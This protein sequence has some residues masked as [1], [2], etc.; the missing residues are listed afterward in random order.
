MLV[1]L[2]YASRA[3]DGID[4]A[5][6]K[7]IQEQSRA[8]N[9]EHGI[10]GILCAHP[11]GGVFIQVLEGGRE[12]VNRLFGNIVRDQRHADVTILDYAEI[13]E[14]R[15]AGWR[16]GNVDLNKVNLSSILR[17]S[18]KSELDPF[19]MSGPSALALL[20][21]LASSAAIGSYDGP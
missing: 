20:E 12:P 21:E 2:L 3:V 15:F 7:S 19:S 14:R 1:R 11:Q 16:M 4:Q 10:T 13:E 6:L 9:L 5:F 18:E 8:S 17:Y